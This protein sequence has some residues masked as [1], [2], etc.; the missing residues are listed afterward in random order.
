MR[1]TAAACLIFLAT[2]PFAAHAEL[3][4]FGLPLDCR[5][6][7]DCFIQNY[8]DHGPGKTYED[9]RCGSL[10]HDGH[11]GTDFR[12][13]DH[14]AMER[15]VAVVA[16]A[17]GTVRNVRDGMPDV[18]VRL[19]GK[20][21][22][23]DRGLGNAVVLDHGGGWRT[24]YGHM[25][26]NSI[27]VS[28]GQHVDAGQKLGLIGLSGLTEF[29]HVHFSIRFGKR[30]VDPFVGLSA[31][32][33]CGSGDNP[34]WR[35][36]L[37]ADLAYRPTFLLSAG[38]S[39][40]PMT[41]QA[42]QYGLYER[43]VLPA[44]TGALYFA[45]FVAGLRK[46]DRLTLQLVDE[47]GKKLRAMGG[48]VEKPAAVRFQTIGHKRNTPLPA[49]RYRAQFALYGKRDGKTGAVIEIDRAVTLR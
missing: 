18:D 21:A 22:V 14:A 6:G 36:E 7:R 34:L 23:D 44:R 4:R 9:Y 43:D 29:P 33:G 16:A 15:G 26:R 30:I 24:I 12:L 46:G 19:V 25:R 5:L 31:R 45:V 8:V 41:R 13:P 49:G 11:K 40:R 27:A 2:A 48:A 10:T 37:L 17:A 35:Q 32:T 38:F 39:D 3:P 20:N 42:L 47:N 28:A 1:R